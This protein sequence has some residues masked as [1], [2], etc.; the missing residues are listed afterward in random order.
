MRQW[1]VH[2]D[3]RETVG[4]LTEKQPRQ[5]ATVLH[6]AREIPA[7]RIKSA[8]RNKEPVGRNIAVTAENAA[9]AFPEIGNHHNVGLVITGAGFQPCL[10]LAHVVG[11]SQVRIPVSAANF[12]TAEFVDQEE[13]DHT[14]DGVGSV[15]SRGAILKDVHVIDH[16]KRYQVNVRASAKAGDAQ[17]AISD[18][19]P[20]DQNQGFLRQETA[21][22][23]LNSAVTAVADVQVHGAAGLLR[24]EFLKVGGVADTQLLNVLRTVC[25]HRVRAGFFRCGNV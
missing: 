19:F 8:K 3:L 4:A 22:V 7:A 25:V 12:Q 16:R 10:P 11:G 14:R 13:V 20:I 5:Q 1:S 2:T 6:T 23:K 15:H 18:P 24:D 17:R 21:Q 9:G